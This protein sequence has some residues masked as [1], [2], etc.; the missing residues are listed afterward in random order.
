MNT[1]VFETARRLLTDIYGALYEMESGHGFRC[2]KAERG[3]I[4]LYR[5]VVGLAEGN[6]GEIAFEIESHARRAGRGVVETR[7]FFRQLKVA[8][9]HPT[10]RDSRYDWP[11][12]GF[13]DKEEVT[14]IV[15][16][17][18]AFLGVGR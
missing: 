1:Y 11:R 10:E 4:F 7:H 17:L 15:L 16:E 14:A 12:I 2:V 18:K 6:L 8:S 3:Q 5:P 13:T 9:G